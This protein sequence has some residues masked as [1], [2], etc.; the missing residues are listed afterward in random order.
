MAHGNVSVLWSKLF[1]C[2]TKN[3]FSNITF[4]LEHSGRKLLS[5][6]SEEEQTIIKF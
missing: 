5:D 2:L 4:L 6:F 1:K 3:L